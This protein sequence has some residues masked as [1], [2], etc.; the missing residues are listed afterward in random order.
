MRH[1]KK[2]VAASRK[3]FEEG[4]PRNPT[5]EENDL[6]KEEQVPIKQEETQLKK[7]ESV[8]SIVS[9]DLPKRTSKTTKASNTTKNEEIQK[10]GR[11]SRS[12]TKKK[13][14][15]GFDSDEGKTTADGKTSKGATSAKNIIK[16]YGRALQNFAISNMVL[17]YLS[18]LIQK[19]QVLLKDFR[20][21]FYSKK[22]QV[23]SIAGLRSL[24][25]VSKEDDAQ[26]AAFKRIFKEISII[27][28]KFFSVN[29]IFSGKLLNKIAHLKCRFKMLRRIKNPENFTYLKGF[30]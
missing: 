11:T 17:P 26:T 27:F 14:E 25:L 1:L 29:W 20:K 21:F 16:N 23:R 6:V 28:I 2:K 4:V 10:N 22:K 19:E 12:T 7:E 3:K 15:K 13:K 8:D 9:T 5:D 18:P 30:L 24:L